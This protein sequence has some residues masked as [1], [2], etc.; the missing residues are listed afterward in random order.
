MLQRNS[1]ELRRLYNYRGMMLWTA[2]SICCDVSLII[3]H[4]QSIITVQLGYAKNFLVQKVPLAVKGY[5]SYT[6]EQRSK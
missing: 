1:L 6:A 5:E 4:F 2:F 3:V